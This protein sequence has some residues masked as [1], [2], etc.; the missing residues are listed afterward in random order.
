MSEDEL[1]KRIKG[2]VR[3][4]GYPLEQRV[5]CTLERKGW[6][7][8]YSIGY[9]DPITGK[10][11]ELDILAYKEVR[12]RR[13]ELR[14]S[15]KRSTAKPW[16][17]FTEDS[18]RYYKHGSILKVTPVSSELSRYKRITRVLSDL[19]FFS[20][21]RRAIN[22]TAFSGKEFSNDARSLVKDGLYSTLNSVYHRLFPH[23]LMFDPRGTVYL[24]LVI[25]DGRM[26]ESFYNIK[27]KD[28]EVVEIEY[29]QWDS[30]LTLNSDIKFIKDAQGKEVALGN[31][32]YWFSDWFRLEIVTW[33]FFER[34]LDLM[35]EV[36]EKVSEKDLSLFGQPWLPEN[37]PSTVGPRPRF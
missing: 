23:A 4:S 17:L 1:I 30:K 8:F 36:F 26:F 34:Y 29:G 33:L 18:T 6:H 35:E 25:L 19:P 37:F 22:F 9:P 10:E 12:K 21:Q 14:I 11:R 27:T 20:H 3:N 5:G 16:V 32:I 7:S 24:F 15:C 13:L 2:A 31:V 28:D